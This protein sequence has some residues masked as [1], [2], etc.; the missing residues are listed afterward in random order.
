MREEW[1]GFAEGKWCNRIDVKDFIQKN[2]T[3]YTGN[4]SFLCGISSKT[5]QVWD[6]CLELLKKELNQTKYILC[7]RKN[8]TSVTNISNRY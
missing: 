7:R 5:K 8:D 3:E 4:E 6:Q 2:Y 1:N